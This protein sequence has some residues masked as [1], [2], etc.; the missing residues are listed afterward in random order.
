[1]NV[2]QQTKYIKIHNTKYKTQKYKIHHVCFHK[3]AK[4][5]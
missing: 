1:M 2:K 3:S 4:K 5:P